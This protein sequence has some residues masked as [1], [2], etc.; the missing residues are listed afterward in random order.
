MT[1]L[2]AAVLILWTQL[3]AIVGTGNLVLCVHDDGESAVEFVGSECCRAAHAAEAQRR[4]N[5]DGD[6]SRFLTASEVDRC[7]DL[8]YK[9]DQTLGS[10][11]TH[12]HLKTIRDCAATPD[13]LVAWTAPTLLA[14]AIEAH[15]CLRAPP[16]G[17][18]PRRALPF[19]LRC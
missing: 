13:T 18:V 9:Q 1:R 16:R 5:A 19:V 10:R 12:V 11:A 4:R 17:P 14:A 8:P 7:T 2:L 6:T 15:A 3:F